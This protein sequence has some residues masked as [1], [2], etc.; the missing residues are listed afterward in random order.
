MRYP[1]LKRA[2]KLSNAYEAPRIFISSKRK[3]DTMYLHNTIGYGKVG[4]G[5]PVKLLNL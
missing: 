2:I 5:G 1:Q 3:N 4:G